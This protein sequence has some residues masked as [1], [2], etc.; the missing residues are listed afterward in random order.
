MVTILL[1][2]DGKNE[3]GQKKKGYSYTFYNIIR[4]FF[5]NLET[6]SADK[7]NIALPY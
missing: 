2:M 1:I 7:K 6:F 3:F 5:V 4:Y